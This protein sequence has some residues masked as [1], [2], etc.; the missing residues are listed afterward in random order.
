MLKR[1]KAF[2]LIL[3]LV[4]YS[5]G[6]KEQV[7]ENRKKEVK[8]FQSQYQ[9]DDIIGVWKVFHIE[10][11]KG[12]YKESSQ[13]PVLYKANYIAAD[14]L[15][16]EFK[17]DLTFSINQRISG[18]WSFKNDS[19]EIVSNDNGTFPLN[20]SSTYSVHKGN[21]GRNWYLYTSFYDRYGKITHTVRVVSKRDLAK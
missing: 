8:T 13:N 2:V 10:I 5:C 20:I 11:T 21:F 6:K 16:L 3:L 12:R 1:S 15:T 18:K 7:T 4:S 17:K 14:S 9:K 19:V